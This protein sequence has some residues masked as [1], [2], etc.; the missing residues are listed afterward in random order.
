[1]V[2]DFSALDYSEEP[3]LLLK[4]LDGTI[5]CPLTHALDVTAKL[6]YNEVSEL[7][8]QI[9]AQVN[10]VATS[11]YDDI[12]GMR[13]VDWMGLGQFILVDPSAETD[14]VT[15]YK[16]CK[17]YSLEYEL[18]HK[19]I[20]VEEGTYDFWNPVAQENTVIGII[21]SLCPAWSVGSIDSDLW[22]K[23]RTFSV[24]NT[25]VYDFI[26]NDAQETYQCVFD[27]DTYH[28]KINVRA[29]SAVVASDPVYL[30]LDNLVKE[31]TVD[32]DTENIFTCLDVKGADDVDIRSVNPMGTNKI[33]NLDYFMDRNY[34][35]ETMKQKW[36]SW[37]QT[38]QDH[39]QLYYN[40]TI[41]KVLQES[42]LETEKAALTRLE[43]ELSQ[44]ETLQS[45]YIEASAQG[46]DQSENLSTVKNLI[47]NKTDEISEKE[48]LVEEITDEI[49]VLLQQ[50][51]SINQACAF[52]SF[53]DEDELQILDLHIVE[54]AI[55]EESF[56]YQTVSSYTAE[57]IAQT[58]QTVSAAFTGGT[59]TRVT[60][61]SGK[62]I[63]AVTGGLLNMTVNGGT[64]AAKIVRAAIECK[65]DGS[66]VLTAYLNQGTYQDVSYPSGCISLTGTGCT[67]TSDVEVDPDIGGDT[68][69]EGTE[70][71]IASAESNLY[72]TVN[73]TEY[74]KRSV[75]WDLMEYGEEALER[76]AWPSYTF[77]IDASNFLALEEFLQFKNNFHLGNRVYLD[78]GSEVLTP[79]VIGTEVEM[80]DP[81]KLKLIFSDA[82]SAKDSAFDLVSLLEES[83]SMGKTVASNVRNFNAFV[84]SG[85]STSVK[86]FISSALDYSKNKILSTGKQGIQIDESGITLRKLKDDGSGYEPEQIKMINNSIVFTNDNWES[87]VMALGKFHDENTGDVW[88]IVAQ[89]IVGT[90]LAGS[91]LVI[92]SSKKDGGVA[93]FR[94]DA[95]GA[96]LYNSRFDLVNEYSGGSSGQISLIPNIGFVG[97]KT[98]TTTP[99]FSYDEQ[100]NVDGVVTASGKT[101]TSAAKVDWDDL[102]NANW[103]VDMDGNVYFKGNVYATDGIFNGVVHAIDG[104]FSGT[105]NATDLQ[106]DGVS[107]SNVFKAIEDESGNLDYLQ[108][109]SITIDGKTGEITF[110]GMTGDLDDLIQVEYST[111][112]SGPWQSDWNS[113][114]TNVE[115]WARYSYDG[116]A[117][118]GPA[119]RFQSVN[120]QDGEDGSDASVPSYIKRTYISSTRIKSPYIQGND[121]S[122]YGSFQALDRSGT[123]RGYMGTAYGQDAN[124]NSTIGVALASSATAGADYKDDDG[125]VTSIDYACG[126]NYVIAT[127][128]GSRMQ[129]GDCSVVT[130][131]SG[132]ELNYNDLYRIRVDSNGCRYTTDG[133]SNWKEIGSGDSTS[134]TARWG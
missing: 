71:S 88:G 83:I 49:D 132:S 98:T 130:T 3:V 129:A 111:S 78:T 30:S 11:H 91:N 103:F 18:N 94:V 41:E 42:R 102:P 131:S 35:A 24:E 128:G 34:F 44:Y 32:E 5:L 8:F 1:M 89:A 84:D 38:Y 58:S 40:I 95:D 106:L 59:V 65:T 127:S 46:V 92:E 100:G 121:I 37:K 16:K 123:V 134:I 52:S 69:K 66:Y 90:L 48:T 28:R 47:A 67:V 29:A 82:Y 50:Q 107:I 79:I 13:V 112:S 101:L 33:Y 12:V 120:G 14:G 6:M 61:T 53:F 9:P 133:G 15:E 116:G 43:N 122:V 96:R 27:F 70:V 73:A 125:N 76:L 22:G 10:G 54:S 51:I 57:D 31:L 45:T 119:T 21:L 81:S 17:A 118:W 110:D 109:G 80:D 126:G 99:L 26:K 55:S 113:S 39:K 72:L 108:I 124:G 7:E 63:Y 60:N 4:N 23:Y 25:S 68:Y 87:A 77:S 104:E 117:T 36:E 114:W 75:E 86:D 85:A 74:A 2:I 64:V 20:Y 62:G 19:Q 105:V 93:V 97:G 56:V 115:V